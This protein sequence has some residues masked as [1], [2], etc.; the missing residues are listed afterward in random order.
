MCNTPSQ[1]GLWAG[2]VHIGGVYSG[3]NVQ[4]PFS[5]VSLDGGRAHRRH[6]F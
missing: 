3:G 4:Y 2:V 1:K 5:E 6:L